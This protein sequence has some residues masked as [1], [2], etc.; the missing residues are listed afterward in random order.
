[1]G[2]FR[3]NSQKKVCCGATPSV[4]ATR[5]GLLTIRNC[6]VFGFLRGFLVALDWGARNF[7]KNNNKLSEICLKSVVNLSGV[8]IL[9]KF[10]DLE[11]SLSKLV[12]F[13]RLLVVW[14]ERQQCGSYL[15]WFFDRTLTHEI[16]RKRRVFTGLVDQ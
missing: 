5:F 3:G 7:V 12:G 16:D 11:K 8:G 15:I 14:N 6:D 10:V 1:V 2:C 4:S 13:G 9:P